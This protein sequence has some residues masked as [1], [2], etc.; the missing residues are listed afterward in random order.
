[1]TYSL[2]SLCIPSHTHTL[3]QYFRS[4]SK[5]VGWINAMQ[6]MTFAVTYVPDNTRKSE[7][8]EDEILPRGSGLCVTWE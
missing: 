3:K 6:D 7:L 4:C 5:T 1:M 2:Y 8:S